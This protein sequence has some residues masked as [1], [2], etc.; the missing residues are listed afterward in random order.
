MENI[1]LIAV[2]IVCMLILGMIGCD[3]YTPETKV[4]I[5]DT[6]VNEGNEGIT[7]IVFRVSITTAPEDTVTV[8]WVTV[9]G[10]AE[11]ESGDVG[12]LAG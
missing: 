3:M 11:D 1:K 12:E 9:S 7:E 10:G 6:S 2:S 8:D 5:H 4:S